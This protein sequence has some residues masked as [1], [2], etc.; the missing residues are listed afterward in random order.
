MGII[1][2]MR[3]DWPLLKNF[4]FLPNSPMHCPITAFSARQDDMV[5]TDEI[6]AWA[7]HTT[8]RFEL[9][10]VDGDHWFLNRNRGRILAT[11]QEIAAKAGRV[12]GHPHTRRIERDVPESSVPAQS[13]SSQ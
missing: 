1:Y 8:G 6:G 3:S 4:R 12:L 2:L 9:I 5:Y 7:Q 11:L 13:A 10:E